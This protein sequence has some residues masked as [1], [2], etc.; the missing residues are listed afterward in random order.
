VKERRASLRGKRGI[1]ANCGV[2]VRLGMQRPVSDLRGFAGV[3]TFDVRLSLPSTQ[4]TRR[5]GLCRLDRVLIQ[6]EESMSTYDKS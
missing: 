1:I 2:A 4:T 3:S 5:G 6:H